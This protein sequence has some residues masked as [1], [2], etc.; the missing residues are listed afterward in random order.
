MS[1]E[2]NN[3]WDYMH[4]EIIRVSKA[5][6]DNEFY[7]D[8]VE[9]AFKEVNSKVKGIYLAKTGKE[10]DGAALMQKAFSP[11]NPIL[12]FEGIGTASA[13]NTQQGYMDIFAGAMTGIRNPKTHENMVI[14]K[15][16]AVQRMMLASLLMEKIDEALEYEKSMQ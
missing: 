6:F 3:I 4:Q 8:A 16:Q 1:D 10:E 5:K 13:K 9:S 7:A 12:C 15:K 11:N 14:D 2:M